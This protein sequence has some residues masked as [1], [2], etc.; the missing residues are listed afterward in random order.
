MKSNGGDA[1]CTSS[2]FEKSEN[3]NFTEEIG[4]YIRAKL[5]ICISV[6]RA[7]NSTSFTL[8]P[9]RSTREKTEFL[10]LVTDLPIFNM[11]SYK[12]LLICEIKLLN[13]H[14]VGN[15][16]KKVTSP[17]LKFYLFLL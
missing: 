3:H 15:L 1:P 5:K 13:Y 6:T 10:T 16:L 7:R 17:E 2:F 14:R 4:T 12:N 9:L 8:V 11:L